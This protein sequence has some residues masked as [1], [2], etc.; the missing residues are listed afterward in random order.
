IQF[1]QQLPGT[2]APGGV[3]VFLRGY[4][5]REATGANDAR[6]LPPLG[7]C[8][9]PLSLVVDLLHPFDGVGAEC[10][11]DGDVCQR[12]SSR[13]VVERLSERTCSRACGLGWY[14]RRTPALA[15]GIGASSLAGNACP[16]IRRPLNSNVAGPPPARSRYQ[17]P[18][19]PSHERT[20]TSSSA[21]T[22]Q[23]T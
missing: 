14:F 15:R 18:L 4:L 3:H 17:R 9:L 21:T 22:I 19:A 23:I 10:F 12:G 8:L 13:S 5:G 16:S 6:E 2:F 1:L 7:N 11:L 20:K